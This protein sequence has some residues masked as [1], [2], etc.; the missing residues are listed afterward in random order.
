[1]PGNLEENGVLKEYAEQLIEDTVSN[2]YKAY[3]KK[4][5]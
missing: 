3:L 5:I 2:E 4:L 1:M